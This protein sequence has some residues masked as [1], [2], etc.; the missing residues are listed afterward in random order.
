VLAVLIAASMYGVSAVAR[1]YMDLLL[2]HFLSAHVAA[3]IASALQLALAVP[4]GAYLFGVYL[5]LLT[6]FG[7]ENTQ[8]FTALDHPGFKHF[9]RFRVRADGTAV[10]GFCIGLVDPVKRGEEPVLVDRFTWKSR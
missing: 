7:F 1:A 6:A 4:V 10:D 9:V 5:A 3:W 2:S 8:A